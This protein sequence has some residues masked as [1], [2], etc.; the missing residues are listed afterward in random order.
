MS[1]NWQTRAIFEFAD[2]I[3][4][5]TPS[6]TVKNYW[7][8]DIVW[9]TPADLSKIDKAFLYTSN[10]KITKD[11]LL[12]SSANIIPKNSIVMSSRAPIGY[13]AVSQVDFST[14]QGCKSIYLKKGHSSLFHYYNFKFNVNKFKSKGEGT[15][16]A[17]ISKKEIEK[18][19]FSF[20]QL[21]EQKK[22]AKILSTCDSVIEKTKE[23]IKKY[24]AI[25][26]G[27]TDDLFTR[28]I[29]PV[30]KK[31]RPSYKDAPELYK[32]SE[33][34]MIPKDWDVDCLDN[35]TIKI[36]DGIHTTPKY[37]E[38]TEYFFINGNNLKNG[39]IIFSKSTN[40]VSQDEYKRFYKDLSLNTIL[41]SIN[42]T[43]GNIAF[44]NGEFVILGKSTAYISFKNLDLMNYIY[45]LIQTHYI[46]KFY[47]LE[48]TGST[49]KNLSLA[50]IRK[51][52]IIL[53]KKEE[54]I[55]ITNKLNTIYKKIQT[56][57][58]TLKKYE[59]IKKGLMDDLLTGKKEVKV[60]E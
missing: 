5:G 33:L 51:T 52:P 13:F 46:N 11:G 49:I 12:N 37:T 29:D 31:L 50:V 25:K 14:N 27:M 26:A 40:N 3:S 4:G 17:E 7:D 59:Q 24:Q 55:E 20:P 15:T 22:I 23:A 34:G 48:L 45:Y 54:Y 58:N 57:Q 30:S 36:G 53:P 43:I 56:E 35:I 39:K 21:L 2:V 9:V 8:G 42:G 32:K 1:N 16:F 38:G 60:K 19:E 18:L 28:G 47:S 41:Y 10:K 44:Y 6:T